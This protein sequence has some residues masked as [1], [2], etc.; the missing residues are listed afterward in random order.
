MSLKTMMNA[1]R[2]K[3]ESVSLKES[4]FAKPLGYIDTGCYALNRIISGDVFLGIP[5]GRITTFY[6]ESGCTPDTATVTVLVKYSDKIKN[7]LNPCSLSA[8]E[9]KNTKIDP[10]QYLQGLL[11]IGYSQ[12][13]LSKE[14]G[15]SRLSIRRIITGQTEK[16][17]KN[18]FA[19]IYSFITR[20][21][22][23]CSI[24][25]VEKIRAITKDFLI[26][27]P[28]GFY[29]S[30][31]TFAKGPK[32][33]VRITTE[34]AFITVVSDDHAFIG[35]D[36][37]WVFAANV[38]IGTELLTE[39]GLDKVV[40]VE[41]V[42]ML[43]CYDLSIEH[44]EHRYYV[45]GFAVHNSGKSRI[46]AQIII[47]AL[48]KHNYDMIFYCDSE[49]GGLYDL[50]VNSGIDAD[51]IE[52]VLLPNIEEALV[53]ML[54]IYAS[55]EEEIRER[56]LKNEA[57]PK[58]LMILDSFG[59]LVSNKT[60]TDAVEKDKQVS[61]MGLKAKLKND[62]IKSMMIPAIKTN[63]ALVVINHVYDNPGA[64]YASKT[65]EQPGGK[66]L[67]FASHIIVQS[68]KSL[69]RD[70][71]EG[72]DEGQSYFKANEI[73]Y[74]TTKNRLVK[75]GY[76]A[77]MMID[78]N[79]GIG[80]WDGLLDEARRYGFIQGGGAGRYQVPSYSDKSL[81]MKEIMGNDEVWLS[82]LNEFNERSRK[83]MQYGSEI[84]AI[85]ANK[86]LEDDEEL[87]IEATVIQ[88][89]APLKAKAS[90]KG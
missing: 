65:K 88:E 21:L 37:E 56:K 47:N 25:Q 44:S 15:L 62:F 7:Y 53:K 16:V 48:T 79:H 90:K 11:D 5:E 58:C 67:Q 26:K 42:G 40:S 6:G 36:N 89:D 75:L 3:T 51:K 80:K 24:A 83:D 18:T 38:I 64:M 45:D 55:I 19:K 30:S 13:E 57:P 61:D 10:K 8:G 43:D 70:K 28:D 72:L 77:K 63:M 69:A 2:K 84:E 22:Y 59:M 54:N 46:V 1:I 68:S 87:P 52:H 23:V 86:V 35:K 29:A 33:C 39:I 76:E 12:K 66:G 32:H 41:E 50:I 31:Q 27:T 74:F 9:L 82:F 78:L 20:N 17:N 4:P 85:M 14:M 49:G 60:Y 34:A 71:E 81:T 73:T